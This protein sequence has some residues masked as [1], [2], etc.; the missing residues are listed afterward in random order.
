MRVLEAQVLAANAAF[1]EAFQRRDVAAMEGL[2]ASQV[3]VACVHPGWTPL[4]GREDVLRS[5][6]AILTGELS[7]RVEC[8]AP[9]VMMLGEHAAQ[10]VCIERIGTSA[11]EG[12]LLVAT[13]VFVREGE[14]WRMANHHA[15]P[16]AVT[17]DEDEISD[18]EPTSR[19]RL[20]N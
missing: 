18:D 19:G 12:G 8:L 16:M 17:D 11:D 10:V 14:D 15:G 4:V 6:R 13:N 2:W 1:Y 3:T 20:L 7:P 9:N 5:W